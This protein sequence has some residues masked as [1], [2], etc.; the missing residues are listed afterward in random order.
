[1]L[2][3][4]HSG[5]LHMACLTVLVILSSCVKEYS[6]EGGAQTPVIIDT[7][8]QPFPDTSTIDVFP[9]C[10]VCEG[11]DRFEE[12]R[13]SFW[14]GSSFVCGFID[15][16]IVNPDRTALTFFGESACSG[17]T[18][19]AISVYLSPNVLNKT[20]QALVSSYV[21]FHFTARGSP[22]F[23]LTSRWGNPFTVTIDSYDH[24]TKMS[25]GTFTGI[26]FKADGNPL[27]VHD[28]KFKVRLH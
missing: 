5:I 18:S 15:T 10:A 23:V 7:T 26:A 12:N 19:L 22:V 4:K 14:A 2:K 21:A 17:D 20:Q 1:M 3:K 6:Y 16:A 28:A 25:S 9:P 27:L 24:Q 11:H 8:Q 13:W